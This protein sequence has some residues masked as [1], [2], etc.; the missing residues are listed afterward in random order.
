MK[1]AR[2]EDSKAQT[3]P[4]KKS[5]LPLMIL[6][7]A[8]LGVLVYFIAHFF[9]LSMPAKGAGRYVPAFGMAS[10]LHGDGF[11]QDSLKG[12]LYLLNIFASWCVP[13]EGEHP[14][15][16]EI[17]KETGAPIYGIA[18]QDKPEDLAR[19]LK[20]LG[21]PYRDIGMDQAGIMPG[22]LG[23]P[24]I[25][26]TFLVNGEHKI[27]ASWKGPLNDDIVQNRIIPAFRKAQ[28]D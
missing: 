11:H 16:V 12:D 27:L 2:P 20:R 14:L 24:G 17:A 3:T 4:A 26:A 10:A 23:T 13:C 28:S 21:N 19:F 7:I 22:A 6:N 5:L 15:L 25:P 9:S 8:L 18:L 1:P